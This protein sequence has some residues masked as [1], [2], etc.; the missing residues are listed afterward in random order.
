MVSQKMDVAIMTADAVEEAANRKE[1][2]SD[3]TQ[4]WRHQMLDH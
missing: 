2:A 1:F 3:G 4:L